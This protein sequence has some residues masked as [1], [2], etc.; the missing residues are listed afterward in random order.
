MSCDGHPAVTRRFPHT[1]GIDA[2]GIIEESNSPDF[3]KGEKVIVVSCAMGMNLAGGFGQ[4]I[5][6]PAK[7]VMKLDDNLSLAE[8]MAYGTAGYT[9]ALS[10]EAILKNTSKLNTLNN[11]AEIYNS[12]VI[13]SGATGGIGCIATAMLSQLGYSITAVTGNLD[14]KN[15]LTDIGASE[16]LDRSELE[17]KSGQNLFTPKWD[18]AIDVAGGQILSNVLKM[19]KDNGLVVATGMAKDTHFDANVLPFILRGITLIGINAENTSMQY[20]EQ[21][22]RKMSTIWKPS[23]FKKLYQ[24]I[25]L[26][27]LPEFMNKGNQNKPFGRTIIDMR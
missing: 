25:S 24:T 8:S 14:A 5:S 20:R 1:P 18:S 26:Q 17:A 4:Y 21:V 11:N 12:Q 2:S 27:D 6:V 3:C 23:N 9:A 13:V 19:I 7:W 10:I 15:I 16:I 22:W